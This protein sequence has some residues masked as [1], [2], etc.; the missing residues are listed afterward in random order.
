MYRDVGDWSPPIF[1]RCNVSNKKLVE[2]S[3]YLVSGI[4]I[5]PISIR[6]DYAHNISLSPPRFFTFRRPCNLLIY[7]KALVPHN[8]A[9]FLRESVIAFKSLKILTHLLL[10][11]DFWHFLQISGLWS[12]PFFCNLIKELDLSCASV[13]TLRNIFFKCTCTLIK[14]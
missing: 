6:G 9:R 5:S 11:I 12:S 2:I 10:I 7:Q 3:N 1:I 8:G 14:S 13:E 4:H